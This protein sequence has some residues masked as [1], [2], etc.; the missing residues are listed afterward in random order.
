MAFIRM[1]DFTGSIE[2]VAFP[3]AYARYKSIIVP[4][5]C[6]ALKAKVSERNGEISLLAENFM[7][8]A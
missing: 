7:A 4:E 6:V 2:A 8:L 5:R 3:R 1:S